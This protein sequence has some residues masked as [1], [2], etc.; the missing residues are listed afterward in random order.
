MRRWWWERGSVKERTGQI[1]LSE[2]KYTR[3]IQ[4][5]NEMEKDILLP[6]ECDLEKMPVN[7]VAIFCDVT[8]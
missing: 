7:T 4:Q 6:A 8:S 1:R 5:T 2:G 3:Y